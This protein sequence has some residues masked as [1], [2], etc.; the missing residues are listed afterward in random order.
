M[1]APVPVQALYVDDE[2]LLLDITRL[3][4]ER[5]GDIAVDIT[6]NPFEAY[7]LI[8]TGRYDV[9]VSDYQMPEIDGITLL[10]RVRAAGSRVPFII[11]TGRGREE[12]VI[13]ALN[14][15]ADFYLQKGGDPKAQFAELANA[16]RQLAGKQKA[17]IAVRQSEEMLHKAESLAHLGSWVF[18]HRTGQ[19]TWSD[20]T[21][22]IFGLEPGERLMTHESFL[23]MVHPDDR[24]MVHA[25]YS[26][27]L[28]EGEASYTIEHRI[29]RADTGEVRYVAERCEHLRD[30]L[31]E[32]TLSIGMAHD[33]T[34]RKLAE[35]E[36]LQR[37]EELRAAYEQ[38]A[39]IE[40]ELR[41]SFDDLAGS[42]R[43]IQE[44][45]AKLADIID[46]LPDATFVIDTDG[47]VIAWNRAMEKM[48][49]IPKAE[50][51]GRGDH[52]YAVPFYGEA[53]PV[54]IDY[55]LQADRAAGCP[56]QIG[57]INGGILEG[58]TTSVRL[59]GRAVAL[60]IRASP[61]YD[62]EGRCAGAIE[63]VRDIT[64]QKQVEAD[65]RE[66]KKYLENLIDHAS[67]AIAVWN[68]ECIITR[69][70]R[71]FEHLT[72]IPAD[73]AIGQKVE[74][75]FPAKNRDAL[76]EQIRRA[77]AGEVCEGVEIPIQHR[78]GSVRTVLWNLANIAGN[79]GKTP[80]STIA[81]GQDITFRKVVET[82]LLETHRELLAA[83]EQVASTEE[84]L[85][86]SFDD[87][88]E[89]QRRLRQSEELYRRISGS[90][91]DVVYACDLQDTGEYAISL[92][93]GA[94]AGITGYTQEEVFAMRCWKHLVH[95]D[96]MPV[97]ERDI[98][99]LSPGMSSVTELRIIRRDGSIRWIRITANCT[100]G[101]DGRPQL[102]GGWQDV[103]AQKRAEEA[104]RESEQHFRSLAD[105]GQAL[106]WASG[107]DAGCEYFNE[108][109]LA[110]T[111]RTL[112][113]EI[114]DGWV[115]GMHPDDRSRSIETFTDASER[116]EPFSRTYRLRRH[117]GEYRWIQDDGSPRYDTRGNF[118]GYIGHCL[119]VTELRQME[120]TLQETLEMMEDIFRVAPTG[121]GMTVDGVFTEAN[122]Q[123]CEIT[124]YA[125]DELIGK[126]MRL[127]Y[128]GVA[129]YEAALEVMRAQIEKAGRCTIETRLMRKDGMSS[130]VQ[131]AIAPFDPADLS[132]GMALTVL[133]ITE[134]KAMERE[135]EFHAGELLRQT[136]D[137]ATVNKK[138]NLMNSITRHDVLNQLTIL[139]GNLSFAQEARP[140]QDISKYLSPVKDAAGRIQ[141]QIEF[142]RDYADLGV[143]E[144]EWQRISDAIRSAAYELPVEDE[145]GNLAIYADP[146]LA[147]VFANLMDNTIRH[148]GQVSRVRV[149]YWLEG[150]GSL[151]L[152]WEDD[153]IG[154]PAKEKEEIF[155][156]GIGKNTGLGLFLIR[157]ILAITDIAITE[158]GEPG[159]GARFEMRVPEGMY[160]FGGEA[161]SSV[162]RLT[163]R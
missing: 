59:A 15:G 133:D 43:R 17:E 97:F 150:D 31:G 5:T 120:E 149:R 122:L 44:S 154:V 130:D 1:A 23:A 53:R 156:Q 86:K 58:E 41:T 161:I 102:Y 2:A 90:I 29:F 60:K 138:L 142:T 81:Q 79:G 80:I 62:R 155:K 162:Y 40:E 136:N 99:S 125:H 87:L 33:I 61:L 127:L 30:A 27:S 69:F 121:I 32:A 70:N 11:F 139:L 114:G 116:R 91:S 84:E 21:Y 152:A 160:R 101:Q 92:I 132:Q 107:R 159:K 163:G 78:S 12:V 104:L 64:A 119:D 16:I 100:T 112:D 55:V 65:L 39:S 89:N 10:K 56:Y 9:V 82:E 126:P 51:L 123:L 144:P 76:M 67:A 111:G 38:L 85:R 52:A 106:I 4:L 71:A 135:I 105:S 63:I 157:E 109:W 124:G 34:E 22:R 151:T 20:E 108:P 98:P 118:L 77:M 72:G 37:H 35:L 50:M 128:P 45:E 141:R 19:S 25:T 18:D 48:T 95:P 134:S 153:G 66:A 54:L 140:G 143:G 115:E 42:Q 145:S 14:N 75:L 57:M 129:E 88:A 26:S 110:F 103:T 8:M 68:P 147:R 47:C 131:L 93:A 46:F 113:E 13:E 3:Y 96:D 7:D 117:D 49:G 148:G 36:L 158:T 137:L 146:M 24:A 73:E 6:A 74:I 28:T 94:V 83:Y